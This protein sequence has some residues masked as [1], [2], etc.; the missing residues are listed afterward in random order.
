MLYPQVVAG[1]G[2]VLEAKVIKTFSLESFLL[3]YCAVFTKQM[4]NVV[5]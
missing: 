3:Y 2:G 4:E 1:G 5:S